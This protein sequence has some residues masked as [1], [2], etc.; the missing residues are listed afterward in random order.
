MAP[1]TPVKSHFRPNE[2]WKTICCHGN[3]NV[4]FLGLDCGWIAGARPTLP[5]QVIER[6]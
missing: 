3:A 2:G 4:A 6:M 1:T 5:I